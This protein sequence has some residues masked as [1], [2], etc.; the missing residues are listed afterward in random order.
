MSLDLSN[1]PVLA[2]YLTV[3]FLTAAYGFVLNAR[4]W[5]GS[6]ATVL[7][8]IAGTL[9]AGVWPV[10]LP[11]LAWA[12]VRHRTRR[13]PRRGRAPV[14]ARK[15]RRRLESGH[16]IPPMTQNEYKARAHGWRHPWAWWGRPYL[17]RDGDGGVYRAVRCRWP[18]CERTSTPRQVA[19]AR[20]G[21]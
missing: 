3:V 18:G 1:P 2:A 17:S 10:G 19:L 4:I 21:R 15:A 14:S 13:H 7:L 8:I 5:N 11:L 6:D 16:T 20:A 12:H 9:T